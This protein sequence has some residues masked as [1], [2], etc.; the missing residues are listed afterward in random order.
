M[1]LDEIKQYDDSWWQR[2]LRD[3]TIFDVDNIKA[4][5]DWLMRTVEEQQ[6]DIQFLVNL[7]VKMQDLTKEQWL[8][9]C[10]IVERNKV[11]LTK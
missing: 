9:Y 10:E 3:R 5:K 6:N 1:N 2:Y 4:Q 8:K 11:D 7:P